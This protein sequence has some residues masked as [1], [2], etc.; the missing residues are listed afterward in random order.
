MYTDNWR[1][2]WKVP[3]SLLSKKFLSD[4]TSPMRFTISNGECCGRGCCTTG[5]DLMS[6]DYFP[7]ED[8]IVL[9]R[10]HKYFLNGSVEIKAHEFLHEYKHPK[11][12]DKDVILQTR[13]SNFAGITVEEKVIS[14][15]FHPAGF[16]LRFWPDTICD[17]A[18]IKI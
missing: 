2:H 13:D 16:V 3:I 10:G 1:F 9:K 7:H 17:L 6:D 15:K 8:G 5:R 14:W 12:T 11:L 18:I 4:R